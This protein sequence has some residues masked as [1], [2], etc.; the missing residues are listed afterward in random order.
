M[1]YI[2][3]EDERFEHEGLYETELYD[4]LID[5]AQDDAFLDTPVEDLV[6][7]VLEIMGLPT[8]PKTPPEPADPAPTAHNSA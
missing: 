1:P 6:A 8:R 3:R 2:E 4:I 7:E 5:L